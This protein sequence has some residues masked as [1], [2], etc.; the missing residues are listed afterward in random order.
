M[1]PLRNVGT[2]RSLPRW[3]TSGG[4]WRVRSLGLAVV[5]MLALA[6]AC[7]SDDE[8]PPAASTTPTA[9][10][11]AVA[12]S[13]D[14]SSE[15][16][17][18]ATVSPAPAVGIWVIDSETG[19]A[20]VLFDGDSRPSDLGALPLSFTPSGA[21]WLGSAEGVA[22]RF[23]PTGEVTATLEAAAVLESPDEAS[24]A[25]FLPGS[26]I[27]VADG[28][29]GA[30][31]VSG[32]PLRPVM[33][34]RGDRVA[35]LEVAESSEFGA[36]SFE[37]VVYDIPNG[38]VSVLATGIELCQCDVPFPLRWSPTGAFIAYEDFG[39]I[40]SDDAE[41]RAG[42][43]VPADGSTA[44]VRVA[45]EPR[46]VLGWF[47]ASDDALLVQRPSEPVFVDPM[48][49]LGKP[50]LPRDQLVR[51]AARIDP[52]GRGVQIWTPTGGTTLLDPVAGVEV[53]RW[54]VHGFAALTPF[55]PALA[56][57]G[58]A[59]NVAPAPNCTGVWIEH[60]NLPEGECVRGA[61]RALWSPDGSM[62]ALLG[63]SG[64]RDRWLE[65]WTF[66]EDPLRVLIAPEADLVEWSADGRY[67]LVAWGFGV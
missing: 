55:G 51:G 23:A 8:P 52:T 24:L 20:A 33:S 36:T 43:V 4:P 14:A 11:S 46:R 28:G 64:A 61:T 13:P 25:Y 50:L 49:G 56:V 41:A 15:A 34:P 66:G 18:R 47:G 60:P 57:D 45:D 38:T 16:G 44:P 63:N 22:R 39:V 1:I 21:I 3:L 58:P 48:T 26:P 35:Y 7:T 62:L 31:L 53:D 65:F 5:L 10:A 19:S 42:Y 59:V 54:R 32:A 67:L 30:V 2:E 12:S 6:A 40:G 9:T 29:A 17:P 37:L 27:L